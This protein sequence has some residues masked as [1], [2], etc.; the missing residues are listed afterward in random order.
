M[1]GRGR[2]LRSA[3]TTTENMEPP[4][5]LE[6]SS[7]TKLFP[8]SQ[9]K[10]APTPE[11]PIR[12]APVSRARTK[13]ALASSPS[14]KAPWW[15]G[16]LC[17][18]ILTLVH[19]TNVIALEPSRFSLKLLVEREVRELELDRGI[20]ILGFCYLGELCLLISEALTGVIV[21]LAISHTVPR[22]LIFVFVPFLAAAFLYILIMLDISTNSRPSLALDQGWP[23][24]ILNSL[25][26]STV[27]PSKPWCRALSRLGYFDR[28]PALLPLKFLR[29][30]EAIERNLSLIN[31]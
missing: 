24:H 30:Q 31:N 1:T 6:E 21:S 11:P 19:F 10:R 16:L 7:S 5:P 29:G 13:L 14:R 23:T 4:T 8:S 3:R 12:K 20:P 17:M 26:L 25:V 9:A 2:V 18:F 27:D 15:A 28:S 22:Q